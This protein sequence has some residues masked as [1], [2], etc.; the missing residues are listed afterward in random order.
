MAGRVRKI[1]PEA[2]PGSTVSRGDFA[3]PTV[4]AAGALTMSPPGQFKGIGLSFLLML[5]SFLHV[6]HTLEFARL[7]DP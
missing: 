3:H 1:A 4:L 2:V 6:D 5:L 7:N